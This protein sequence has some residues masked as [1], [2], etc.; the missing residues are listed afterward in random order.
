ME[1]IYQLI[2][3]EAFKMAIHDGL[4]NP[5]PSKKW[6]KPSK[7]DALKYRNSL[8]ASNRDPNHICTGSLG[9]YLFLK[10]IKRQSAEFKIFAEFL[11]E[12]AIYRSKVNPNME[13]MARNIY[14]DYI[15]AGSVGNYN[16][17]KVFPHNLVR[18]LQSQ[19]DEKSAEKNTMREHYKPYI[20]N[21]GIG[22][23]TMNPIIK[24]I[25]KAIQNG[26]YSVNL[27]DQCDAAIFSHVI[28]HELFKDFVSSVESFQYYS[29][30]FQ[31]QPQLPVCE[32]DF[33][34]LRVLGRG[35]FGLVSA[36]VHRC[37]G[38]VFAMK[39]INKKR[40]KL[41]TTI[42]SVLNEKKLLQVVDSQ[43]IV[44]L[45]YAFATTTDLVF[46]M[47]LMLGGDLEYHLSTL[48]TF[49]LHY[50][51]YFISRLV[52]SVSIL[53]DLGIVHR[54]LKPSNIL[55]DG[56][57]RTRLCD[58]GLS[59]FVPPEGL[60]GI[61]GTAGYMAPEMRKKNQN[62]QREVYFYC[63]DWFSLGC[64]LYRF[65]CGKLPKSAQPN[66]VMAIPVNA[67]DNNENYNNNP[68]ADRNNDKKPNDQEIITSDASGSEVIYD[69]KYF[70]ENSIDLLK[71]LLDN[72]QLTRLGSKG[73]NEIKNHIWF[74][75]IQWE[76]L[77]FVEPPMIPE[78]KINAIKQQNIGY[79]KDE[80]DLNQIE[81]SPS[82]MLQYE[83]WNYVCIKNYQEEVVEFLQFEEKIGPIIAEEIPDTNCFL[84][85]CFLCD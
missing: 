27:F 76:N 75:D 77:N 40:V 42:Q 30:M 23:L 36:C 25:I 79:F 64:I 17:V 35:G 39:F 6:N 56:T 70:D 65:L 83:D 59:C 60:L 29:F 55:M 80:Q 84:W 85:N 47:D 49:P 9:F 46:V 22:I 1:E 58:L 73:Y 37:S 67:G 33:Q 10:F 45:K 14:N 82:D 8:P 71:Q 81:L 66:N 44:C 32:D 38:K 52:E 50:T 41:R 48:K 34:P 61:V 21:N 24:N 19:Q 31:T 20:A 4:N 3:D 2:E 54:D 57:G 78:Q 7:E 68:V 51:K 69:S 13:D 74:K 72:N 63:V 53:H 15:K 62:G 28:S 11:I 5:K 26:H 18:V 43:F 16:R 12:C